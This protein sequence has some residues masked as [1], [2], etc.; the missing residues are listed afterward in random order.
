MTSDLNDS[1]LMLSR[2]IAGDDRARD[3]LFAKYRDRLKRMVRLRLHPQLHRRVDESDIIQEAFLEASR[4]LGE[5]ES[6]VPC[7]FFLWLRQITSHKLVDVHRRHLGAARR[8]LR[9]ELQLHGGLL[10]TATSA[11]L[12]VQLL[13]GLT[14]PSGAAVKAEARQLIHDALQS[15][16]PIDREVL[17]L[18]H[19][20]QLSNGEA[21]RILEIS[22]SA[23]SNRY[24]RALGR[25]RQIV[26]EIPGFH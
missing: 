22:E 2:A 26:K 14:S 21:A 11:S 24:V 6:G 1:D 23:C 8:D 15:L 5:Y 4:R 18:R 13:A 17:A 20:E 3:T 19:F 25:L 10:P 9:R 16:D 12:A 7:S